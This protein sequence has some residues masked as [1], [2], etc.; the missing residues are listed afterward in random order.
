MSRD[1]EKMAGALEVV[2]LRAHGLEIGM[3]VE[4]S[5]RIAEMSCNPKVKKR[6]TTAGEIVAIN[7]RIFTIREAEFGKMESFLLVDLIGTKRVELRVAG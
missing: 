5:E 6:R 2:H 1:A 4:I 3:N 7:D